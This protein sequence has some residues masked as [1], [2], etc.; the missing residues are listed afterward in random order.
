MWNNF[1]VWNDKEDS[2]LTDHKRHINW[3]IRLNF[4]FSLLSDEGRFKWQIT[5]NFNQLWNLFIFYFLLNSP[6]HRDRWETFTIIEISIC[7]FFSVVVVAIPEYI[8]DI[9][10]S[11][12]PKRTMRPMTGSIAR[13][14]LEEAISSVGMNL[15]VFSLIN[16]RWWFVIC[17]FFF[18]LCLF[19]IEEIKKEMK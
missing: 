8:F 14:M 15:V 4:A 7:M 13:S 10:C 16:I 2:K 12:I 11:D 5:V 17:F 19:L 6:M 18:W 3:L 1:H 9:L